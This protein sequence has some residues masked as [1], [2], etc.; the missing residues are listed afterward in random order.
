LPGVHNSTILHQAKKFIGEIQ[1]DDILDNEDHN[2]ENFI[3]PMH[4]TTSPMPVSCFYLLHLHLLN[5]I[6]HQFFAPPYFDDF[7]S[8]DDNRQEM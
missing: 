1:L 6:P 5:P 3:H 8:D 2:P 7:D 4:P